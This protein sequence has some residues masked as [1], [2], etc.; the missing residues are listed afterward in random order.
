MA[1]VDEIAQRLI[2]AF[3]ARD[4]EN[5]VALVDESVQFDFGGK[6]LHGRQQLKDFVERQ[7]YG[8]AYRVT[9]GRRFLRGNELVAASRQELTYVGTGEPAG[10][11]ELAA[12]YVAR[13]GLLIRYA[14]FA[15]LASAFAASSVSE[16]DEIASR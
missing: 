9:L 3:N 5:L 7:L 13:D 4:I 6:T 15:G 1:K 10:A 8:A 12:L 16:D 2:E 11:E 14:E